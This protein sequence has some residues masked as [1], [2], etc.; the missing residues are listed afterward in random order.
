MFELFCQA[1]SGNAS[2]QSLTG[3]LP[4]SSSP[5]GGVTGLQGAGDFLASA[6]LSMLFPW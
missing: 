2:V 4:P 5:S 3:H 6:L 1:T